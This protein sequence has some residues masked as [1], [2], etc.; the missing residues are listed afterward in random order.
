MVGGILCV[1]FLGQVPNNFLLSK[2]YQMAPYGGFLLAASRM[3]PAGNIVSAGQLT[4]ARWT[5]KLAED[6][7][8]PPRLSGADVVDKKTLQKTPRSSKIFT[9]RIKWSYL[10]FGPQLGDSPVWG[11]VE[12]H[13]IR[14]SGSTRH[15]NNFV[16]G[17]KRVE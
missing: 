7:S 16:F 5:E 4:R 17:L 8:R 2:S 6:L 14:W 9:E 3:L 15:F 12:R 10:V 13:H 11:S 1:L